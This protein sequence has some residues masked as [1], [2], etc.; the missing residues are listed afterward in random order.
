MASNVLSLL[1][2][3][4]LITCTCP[5][6]CPGRPVKATSRGS[7]QKP[8]Q[9]RK[10]KLVFVCVFEKLWQDIT[11]SLMLDR[12][13]VWILFF[14]FF[15]IALYSFQVLRSK[16]SVKN[17]KPQTSLAKGFTNIRPHTPN[18]PPQQGIS[19]HSGLLGGFSFSFKATGICKV[20]SSTDDWLTRSGSLWFYRWF[21]ESKLL[22]LWLETSKSTDKQLTSCEMQKHDK[23]TGKMVKKLQLKCGFQRRWITPCSRK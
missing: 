13:W 20:A 18:F 17:N 4:Y 9:Y 8:R 22:C 1:R 16:Q 6:V 14:F 5:S 19:W 2:Y 12:G 21:N 15:S 11:C 3:T 10:G 7:C 23:Q